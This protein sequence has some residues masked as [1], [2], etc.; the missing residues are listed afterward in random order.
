[1]LAG[2]PPPM[3]Q[4]VQLT[5]HRR[6]AKRH[7]VDIECTVLSEVYGEP[8]PFRIRD[9]SA[10]GLFAVSDLPLEP[11]DAVVVELI[12]PHLGERWCVLGQ[13]CR[14]ELRRDDGLDA[15]MGVV[16]DHGDS[17]LRGIL[18]GSLHRLPPPLPRSTPDTKQELVWVDCLLTWEEDLGDQ[19]NIWE[20]SDLIASADIDEDLDVAFESLQPMAHPL[21][22]ARDPRWHTP[23]CA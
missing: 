10:D 23:L 9:L 5:P 7:A 2:G 13:V 4:P 22:S 19:I 1:M 18:A 21:H 14:T 6:A 16:F 11:G 20:V 8:I 15:G 3:L 17:M 12:P